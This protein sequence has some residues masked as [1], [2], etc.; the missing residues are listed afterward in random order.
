MTE[1]RRTTECAALGPSFRDMSSATL[2]QADEEA[3]RS[4]CPLFLQWVLVLAVAAVATPHHVVVAEKFPNP[5]NYS[6]AEQVCRCGK[7]WALSAG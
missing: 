1:D 6:P 7:P 5:H 3:A 4:C 2:C